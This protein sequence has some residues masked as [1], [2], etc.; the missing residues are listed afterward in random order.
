MKYKIGDRIITIYGEIG[1]I[2]GTNFDENY[3]YFVQFDR[4]ETISNFYEKNEIK[5]IEDPNNILKEI[6]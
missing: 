2:K 4:H 6:L 1:T 5:L 3:P